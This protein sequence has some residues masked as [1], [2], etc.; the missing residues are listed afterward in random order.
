M[1]FLEFNYFFKN[2]FELEN[3]DGLVDI[4]MILMRFS[5]FFFCSFKIANINYFQETER[6]KMHQ[7]HKILH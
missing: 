1:A 2:G 3:T 6:L 5:V 7:N 4:T